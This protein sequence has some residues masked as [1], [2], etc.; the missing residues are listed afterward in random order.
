MPKAKD[1]RL[2]IGPVHEPDPQVEIEIGG[3]TL[4]V[5]LFEDE[6]PNAVANFVALAE[7]KYFDGL[8]V[9]FVGGD[10]RLQTLPKAENALDAALAYEATTRGADAGT[11]VLAKKG[12]D[13]AAGG[14]QILLRNVPELKDA[15]VFGRLSDVGLPALR[16]LKK[17]ETIK[18]VKVVS[19][20]NHPYEPKRK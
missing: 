19:K 18:S 11:L 20:R 3:A 8:K 9:E 10:E 1:P 14:F 13:N 6:A 5:D 4:K 15:T 2:E 17:D 16:T 12:I 7:Q